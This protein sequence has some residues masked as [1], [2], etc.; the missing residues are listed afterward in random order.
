MD[1]RL[2][3]MEFG[4]RT[5]DSGQ[6]RIKKL[7]QSPKSKVEDKLQ[8]TACILHHATSYELRVPGNLFLVSCLED[9]RREERM[10]DA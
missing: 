8:S 10:L 1:Y 9:L 5:A 7:L 4:H 3:N 6:H 2:W